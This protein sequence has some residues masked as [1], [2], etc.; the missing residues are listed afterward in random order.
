M[1]SWLT[2]LLFF[3]FLYVVSYSPLPTLADAQP[4]ALAARPVGVDQFLDRT[5][6]V[7]EYVEPSPSFAE[8]TATVILW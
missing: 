5:T 1:S 7:P 6:T 4:G 2:S 8:P 3:L